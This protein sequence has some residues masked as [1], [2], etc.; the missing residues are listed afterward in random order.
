MQTKVSHDDFLTFHGHGKNWRIDIKPS[1]RTA[2][3]FYD[4]AVKAAELIAEEADSPIYIMF[5]GGNDCEYMVNVFNQTDIDFNIGIISYGKDFKYN[6]HDTKY[7]LDWCAKHNKTPTIID[8]DLEDFVKSGRMLD[9]AEESMCCE[10]RM[11]STMEGASKVDG[12]VVMANEPQVC[13]LEDYSWAWE[14]H[15]RIN[16]YGNWWESRGIKGTSDFGSYTGEQV[17]AFLQEPIIKRL[18]NNELGYESSIPVK[19]LLYNQN[20]WHQAKRW[21]YTGWERFERTDLFNSLNVR[22]MM[23]ELKQQY[24][25]SYYLDYDETVKQLRGIE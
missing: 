21:K 24:N 20:S 23:N 10:Y 25:G 9:V 4:E 14:E 7:A 12:T 6:A 13:Q 5:G 8:L 18:V 17:L 2:G 1:P 15:E 11:T 22:S 3:S 19:Q 16:S